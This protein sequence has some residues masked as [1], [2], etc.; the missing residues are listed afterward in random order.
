MDALDQLLRFEHRA[1]ATT[2]ELMVFGEK[3]DVAESA[4]WY[5]FGLIDK[6]EMQLS[7]FVNVSEVAMIAQLKPGKVY[8][9]NKET[10]DLILIATK[11]CDATNGAFDV[12]V[13]PM[14]DA[15]AKVGNR[16][17]A[18]TKEE[19]EDTLARC[20]M[21][22]LVLDPDHYLVSVKADALG[23]DTPVELDFGAIGKGFALDLAAEMLETEWEMRNFLIH[24]GTST[25]LAKGEMGDGK[26]GWA[27]TVGGYWRERAGLDA[28]RLENGAISGSGFEE[29]GQHVIDV[30]RGVA[31]ARH[32]GTWSYAPDGARADALSTAFLGMDWK[33]IVRVCE[34]DLPGCG[35]LAVRE[36]PK[37]LDRLR[38]PARVCGTF[39]TLGKEKKR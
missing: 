25:I 38:K 11:V 28:V 19:R 7:R 20:G 23:R 24:G 10:M 1:M 31:A 5:A 6:L 3:P 33:E 26:P 29:Q 8:R 12:T 14:M 16:W 21:N 35:A 36:Q 34:K 37:Y 22:R 30:R 2:F 4:A 9:V 39:P 15:L 18:L 13:G 17:A 27:V 32:A